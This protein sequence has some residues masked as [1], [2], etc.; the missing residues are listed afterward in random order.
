MERVSYLI[1]ST[2]GNIKLLIETDK[3][4]SN[5]NFVNVN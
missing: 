4:N 1:L 2:Y 5:I 3:E